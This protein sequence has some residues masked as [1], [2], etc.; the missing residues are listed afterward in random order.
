MHIAF[1]YGI[2]VNNREIVLT[3]AADVHWN[4]KFMNYSYCC[5]ALILSQLIINLNISS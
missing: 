1:K 4:K 3:G 2:C 5:A